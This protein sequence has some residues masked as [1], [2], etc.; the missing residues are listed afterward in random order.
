MPWVSRAQSPDQGK[1]SGVAS[2][3]D[4]L[5][6]VRVTSGNDP[7][8]I[9][10]HKILQYVISTNTWTSRATDPVAT[11]RPGVAFSNGKLYLVG[12]ELA[13]NG[14]SANIREWTP[15][16]NVWAT[17][18]AMPAGKKFNQAQGYGTK[19]LAFGG[20]QNGG[21][22]NSTAVY[23]Y[24]T[25][26]NSWA[27]KTA[28][29]STAVDVWSVA[30]SSSF[31]FNNRVYIRSSGL[32]FSVFRTD[33]NVWEA[34]QQINMAHTINGRWDAPSAT[35]NRVALVTTSSGNWLF[36][37]ER[38]GGDYDFMFSVIDLST[39]LC[40]SQDVYMLY[41]GINVQGPVSWEMA[42][43]GTMVANTSGGVFFN[44][45]DT[46]GGL[47]RYRYGS[48]PDPG[49]PLPDG[50]TQTTDYPTLGLLSIP[51]FI[52]TGSEYVY[53]EW[54]LATDAGFTAN[55]RTIRN[56]GGFVNPFPDD[57]LELVTDY[58]MGEAYSD[59]QETLVG[60][61]ALFS[62]TWYLRVRH[63]SVPH[64]VGPWNAITP[65][66]TV[67]HP[68]VPSGLY[69]TGGE[70]LIYG[71]LTF[72]WNFDD[73]N[74]G[75]TQSAYQ[76]IVE[77]ND[78]GATV[79]DTGKTA[80]VGARSYVWSSPSS[81]LKD[82]QLRW[83]L[84]VWDSDD[85][86]GGYSSLRL[87]RLS[88][89]PVATITSP[90]TGGTVS[91]G[92]P[93]ITWTFA[94]GGG[95]TQSKYRVRLTSASG[96]VVHADSGLVAG[97]A[98]SWTPS[99]QVLTTGITYTAE[100][101]LIDN[102]GLTGTDAN[103]FTATYTAPAQPA[104]VVST[105]LYSTTGP[106]RITWTN[107]AKDASFVGWRVY[108]K[109]TSAST[110]DLLYD[111]PVDQSSYTYDD[112]SAGSGVQ[113]DYTVVQVAT[114]FSAPVESNKTTISTVTPTSGEY[115]LVCVENPSLTT[116]LYHVTAEDFTSDVEQE[117]MDLIGRGRHTDYGTILGYS[118]SLSF[119]LWDISGGSS[120]RVQRLNLEAM[121]FSENTIYLRNP[122]GDVWRVSV[123]SVS[124]T[125][126][127]GVGSSEMGNGTLT[128]TEV[129]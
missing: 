60:A 81:T 64:E 48:I 123:N 128:Y 20:Q 82:I 92:A 95:R 51:N 25:V 65:T 19:V 11:G 7:E 40:Y 31:W 16:T 126:R 109:K 121:R 42:S 56:T 17:K 44:S 26:G 1:W 47:E 89:L 53:L 118:G 62:G 63:C 94:A 71:S 58:G 3:A 116:R 124:F 54:Q 14:A 85:T 43:D 73:T 122:F 49:R 29:A 32:S 125:R 2:E 23:E 78:T 21:S 72:L 110:W 24:D 98:T 105:S 108:R 34:D 83:K 36:G 15:G 77:R 35:N 66:F 6:F 39:W 87:F 127:A 102:L 76:L 22:T 129:D 57:T 38:R 113:Y 114:R 59:F 101:T 74:P 37:M 112:Y 46:V 117:T 90:A 91:T 27:T 100:L 8:A 111:T 12:G 96:T 70:A 104:F 30:S 45:S 84:R 97:G 50:S 67:S 79:L 75:D 99:S 28:A 61:E 115:W 68:P 93:A 18:T 9:V 69:P 86:T 33:T 80:S 119:Q 5:Y 52:G 55:V 103:T 10:T 41:P 88:D 106:V 120:A 13:A 107:A 4:K